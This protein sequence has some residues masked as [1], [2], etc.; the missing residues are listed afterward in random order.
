[1]WG[2]SSR[3]VPLRRSVHAEGRVLT[4]CSPDGKYC[5]RN[6]RDRCYYVQEE[7]MRQAA[8]FSVRASGGCGDAG[9]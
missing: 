3:G 1:M 7:A 5:F 9:R 4:A 8:S 6:H 2:F